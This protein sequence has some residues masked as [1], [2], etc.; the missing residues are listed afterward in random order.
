MAILTSS[1]AL[2]ESDDCTYIHQYLTNLV[3]PMLVAT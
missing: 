1:L 2:V 3:Y